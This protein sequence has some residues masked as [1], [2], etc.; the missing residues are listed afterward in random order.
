MDGVKA[1]RSL[2]VR[3]ATPGISWGAVYAQ[4]EIPASKAEA[5][6]EGLRIERTVDPGK[7]AHAIRTGDRIHVRYVVTADRD[8]EYVRLMA[9][10]PASAEPDTQLSGYR[11]QGGIGYYRAIHDAN[12]EFFFD[13]LPRGTYVIE[14]DWILSH[15]GTFQLAPAT[16]QCLYAPE[17][18]A[19]TAGS[20]MEV[21]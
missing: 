1:P 19:H 10:R 12:S 4:Y 7:E 14:E 18:Q 15:S 13:R 6:W 2:T 16:L 8:Y 21:K 11:W 17:Y 3:K 5:Q 9:P 20:Q